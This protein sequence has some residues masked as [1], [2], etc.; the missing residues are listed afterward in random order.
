MEWENGVTLPFGVHIIPGKT[1]VSGNSDGE[2][3]LQQVNEGATRKI[4][5]GG[6]NMS[7]FELLKL[8]EVIMFSYVFS[9]N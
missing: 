4:K 9:Y 3:G 6:L 8:L 7:R 2:G 1:G 5:L